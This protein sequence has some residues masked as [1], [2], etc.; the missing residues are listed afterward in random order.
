[1]ERNMPIII[2]T[3]HIVVIN[4]S[5][6]NR[7]CIKFHGLFIRPPPS[8]SLIRVPIFSVGYRKNKMHLLF[9]YLFISQEWRLPNASKNCINQAYRYFAHIL[10]APFLCESC[11][12]RSDNS[13][14]IIIFWIA[15]IIEHTQYKKPPKVTKAPITY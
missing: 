8:G 1:M 10:F 6:K 9:K 3:N 15:E 5:Y 7:W 4:K 13:F 12:N 14:R 11:I 2:I